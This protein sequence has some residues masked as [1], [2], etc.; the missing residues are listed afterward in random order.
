MT[1]PAEFMPEARLRALGLELP[2]PPRP[3]GAYSPA[4]LVGDL[5]FL[6]GQFPIEHGALRF[7]GQIGGELT[8]AQGRA[9]AQLAAL[10]VLAQIHAALGGFDRL[11]RLARVEGHVASAPGWNQAPAVLDAASSLFTT[12]LGERGVHVRSAFTPSRLPL[13]LAV[14]LVV[15]AV[16]RPPP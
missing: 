14:E 8:V 12:V 13:D 3:G 16:V 2:V 6:S 15:T 1:T 4:V 7:T 11:V 5:L 10:N 9:A